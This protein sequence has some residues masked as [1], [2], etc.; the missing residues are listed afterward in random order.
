MGKQLEGKTVLL[1]V[2]PHQFR[3]EEVFEP[4]RILEKEGADVV[5]ASTTARTCRG[6]REGVIDATLAIEEAKAESFDAAVL[7]GGLS[8]PDYFWKDN[9]L[10]EFVAAMSE[11]GRL[12]AAISLSTVV[13][14][15]AKLLEGREATVYY[16]PEA[17]DELKAGGATY[18]DKK[19]IVDGKLVMAE[20][21]GAVASF[22]D[23]IVTVLAAS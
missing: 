20:G 2:P 17:L 19:L 21:P 13:L 5:V 18:V 10:I 7:A 12:V 16:L 15:K 14:A 23:A 9:K 4:K 3:E 22:S 6:T 8:V 1:I 11:A